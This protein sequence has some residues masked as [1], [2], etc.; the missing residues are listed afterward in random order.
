MMRAV[1]VKKSL[2]REDDVERIFSSV[3]IKKLA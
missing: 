1:R 3:E 2:I